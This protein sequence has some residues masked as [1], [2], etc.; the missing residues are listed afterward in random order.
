M[1]RSTYYIHSQETPSEI[2]SSQNESRVNIS[3]ASTSST[4]DVA[5]AAVKEDEGASTSG[6]ISLQKSGQHQRD[7]SPA[8]SASSSKTG[9]SGRFRTW[10]IQRLELNML[11]VWSRLLACRSKL[12]IDCDYVLFF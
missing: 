2:D 11:T 1:T 6:D 8:K 12:R 5:A 4:I 10:H 9:G 7:P 3:G